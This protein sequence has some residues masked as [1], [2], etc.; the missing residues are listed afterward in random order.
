VSNELYLLLVSAAS[1]GFVHT[2]LGPDHYIPFIALAKA[3][4][5]S[6]KKLLSVTSLCG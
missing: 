6:K 1:I 2:L 5:W 4:D 3:G